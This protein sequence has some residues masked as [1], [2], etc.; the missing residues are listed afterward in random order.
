MPLFITF[1]SWLT[2]EIFPGFPVR[3]YSLMYIFAFVTAFILYRIQIKERRFPMSEDTL[4]SLFCWGVFGLL[5]GARLFHTLIYETSDFY[6]RQPWLIFWPFYQGRFTGLQG[7]SYHGG[8]FMGLL[9]V[10]IFAKLKKLNFRELGDM[11]AAAIPLGFTFGRIGNFI[12]AELYGRV[13]AGPFGVLFPK[14][15]TA[16]LPTSE[17]W[18]QEVAAKTNISI[19]GLREVNLP[20]HPSQLYEA[21]FEGIVLWA[22]IW[23]FRSRKPFKGFLIG[24]YFLGYGFFRFIIEYFREPDANIG[25]RFEIVKTTLPTAYAHPLLSFSTGQVLCFLMMVFGGIWLIIA[26][27]MP[28][29][30]TVYVY[31]VIDEEQVKTEEAAKERN[32][33]RKLRKKLR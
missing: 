28:D 24:L 11:F 6:R 31:D 13:T 27:R 3:W 8:A 5:I 7:M 12:N 32:Q 17:N 20:R 1:P 10:V 18:V 29:S 2:P 26:S 23:F 19:A 33:R 21:F 25:Y 30:K 22:I 15:T 9:S 14:E 16:P 4:S